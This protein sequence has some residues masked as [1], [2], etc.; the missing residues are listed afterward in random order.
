[1][2]TCAA[3]VRSFLILL[4]ALSFSTPALALTVGDII[5]KAGGGV[6]DGLAATSAPINSPQKAALD[7][8]NSYIADESNHRIR[9]MTAAAGMIT[10]VAGNGTAAFA[11]DNGRP[12]APASFLPTTSPWTAV[13]TSIFADRGNHRIRMVTAVGSSL[14]SPV[15]HA[16]VIVEGK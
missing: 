2:D 10:T 6:G 3:R 8:G 5:T 1:M 15:R 4:T 14:R 7:S 16:T 13:A 9:K 11:G 12:P